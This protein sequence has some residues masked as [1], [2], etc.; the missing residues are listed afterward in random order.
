MKAV[1]WFKTIIVFMYLAITMTGLIT[2][3][4]SFVVFSR[5]RFSN[6]IFSTYFRL[7]IIFQTLNLILPINQALELNFNI[8]F[9]KLSNF[10]CKF[11][12]YLAFFNSSIPAWL[13]VLISIDRFI[14]IAYPTKF[15]F[16][17]TLKFQLITCLLMAILNICVYSPVLL[18]HLKKSEI[19]NYQTNRSELT[20]SCERIGFWFHLI[21][22]FQS[23][24][25]P[26]TLMSLTSIFTV[27]KVFESR[28]LISNNNSNKNKSNDLKFA[29][30][31][32]TTNI[33]FLAYSVPYFVYTLITEFS[34]L[35]TNLDTD[36][37]L[38]I[39]SISYLCFFVHIIDVFFINILVNSLFKN[40]LKILFG[41]ENKLAPSQIL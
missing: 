29:I 37:I 27:K 28:K 36:V 35:L 4:L 24:I 2:N 34:S 22:L 21:D 25:I 12:T 26:F 23:T 1:Y 38:L 33:V 15:L 9:V 19:F 32:I 5:K 3:T 13:L 14:S 8:Y 17:N 18:F 11:F 10:T 20:Y 39:H 31:S 30:I 16:K 41:K 7:Y 6:T 40:E